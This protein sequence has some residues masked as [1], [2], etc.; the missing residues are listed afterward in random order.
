VRLTGRITAGYTG[1]EPYRCQGRSWHRSR[2][3]AR[4]LWISTVVVP[5]RFP[6]SGASGPPGR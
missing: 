2:C 6:P 4:C 3:G 5:G 1:T